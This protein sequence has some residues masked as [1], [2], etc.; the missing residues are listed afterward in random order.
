MG[1][2]FNFKNLADWCCCCRCWRLVEVCWESSCSKHLPQ[3]SNMFWSFSMTEKTETVHIFIIKCCLQHL[4]SIIFCST[5]CITNLQKKWSLSQA[6]WKLFFTLSATL[7]IWYLIKNVLRYSYPKS[8]LFRI[9]YA[10]SNTQEGWG[11]IHLLL[12][13]FVTFIVCLG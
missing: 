10:N 2:E 3:Y 13:L 9:T 11:G 12:I 7:V 6:L 4:Y 5:L 1:N 8:Q